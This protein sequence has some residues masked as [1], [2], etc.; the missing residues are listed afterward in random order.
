MDSSDIRYGVDN[1][2]GFRGQ[3]W[4]LSSPRPDWEITEIVANGENQFLP[5]NKLEIL[6]LILG[7][8]WRINMNRNTTA[9]PATF[10]EFSPSTV[11]TLFSLDTDKAQ[12][13]IVDTVDFFRHVRLKIKYYGYNPKGNR[14][15][16]GRGNPVIIS[17][18]HV[19]PGLV[20]ICLD[21]QLLQCLAAARWVKIPYT[22]FSVSTDAADVLYR[23]CTYPHSGSI[24][25]KELLEAS[26][27]LLNMN[28]EDL[29]SHLNGIMEEIEEA[30]SWTYCDAE[31]HSLPAQVMASKTKPF[32]L[33]KVTIRYRIRE[34]DQMLPVCLDLKPL[35]ERFVVQELHPV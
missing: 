2:P 8:A 14:I 6:L 23:L 10:F 20:Q 27:H 25:V 11:S 22:C 4:G 5:A 18:Y 26:P 21:S 29:L 28:K 35:Y 34:S 19:S 1:A 15:I 12:E 31:G 3:F 17:S 33:N 7:A 9:P 30:V 13:A 16:V 32:L 24:G